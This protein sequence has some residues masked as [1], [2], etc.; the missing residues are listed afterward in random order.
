MSDSSVHA[1]GALGSFAG[2]VFP[3][4]HTHCKRGFVGGKSVVEFGLFQRCM[5]VVN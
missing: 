4:F 5:F 2:H 1:M 3:I